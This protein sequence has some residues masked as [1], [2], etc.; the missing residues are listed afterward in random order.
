MPFS[1]FAA[2][3]TTSSFFAGKRNY[4]YM[5][6]V[7]AH[8]G[9]APA[10]LSDSKKTP[11]PL[12]VICSW[13]NSTAVNFLGSP[14]PL[15][16]TLTLKSHTLLAWTYCNVNES[17]NP[18]M[19]LQE[20]GTRSSVQS[21]NT[22]ICLQL[23]WDIRKLISTLCLIVSQTALNDLPSCSQTFLR[24]IRTS[25][26]HCLLILFPTVHGL[27]CLIGVWDD[28]WSSRVKLWLCPYHRQ[29]L[30]L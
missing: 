8:L 11:I 12:V 7:N 22:R 4:T 16:S 1:C 27:I 2:I 28:A 25:L 18:L 5:M 3:L 30:E 14:S 13:T 9:K 15:H 24:P 20:N 29:V 17:W 21:Y 19:M 6:A 26:E 23:V 10:G